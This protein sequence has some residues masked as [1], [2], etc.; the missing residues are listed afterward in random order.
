AGLSRGIGSRSVQTY[1]ATFQSFKIGDEEIRNPRLRF[2]D[3]HNMDEDMLIGA[4]FFLSHR[5]FVATNQRKLYATFNGGPVF[6]LTERSIPGAGGEP[7]N[8]IPA[9]ADAPQPEVSPDEPTDAA[10]FSRRG[11]AFA[12]RRDFQHAIEDLS[13]A[14]ELAPTEPEYFFE[15]A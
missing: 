6:N 10:G 7:P 3:I 9:S 5:I 15:R 4:D 1:I 12:A 14:C 8:G 13:Q 2:G 11:A